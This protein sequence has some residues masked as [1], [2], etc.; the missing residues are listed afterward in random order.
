MSLD[1][2]IFEARAANAGIDARLLERLDLNEL[3]TLRRELFEMFHVDF[4]SEGLAAFKGR[5]RTYA[6]ATGFDPGE[7]MD[8]ICKVALLYPALRRSIIGQDHVLPKVCRA[9]ANGLLSKPDMAR[10]RPK[11]S[12]MFLGPTGVGKTELALEFTRVVFDGDESRLV[13]LDMSEFYHEDSY[14]LFAGR[15]GEPGRIGEALNKIESGGTLLLDEIEKANREIMKYLLQML[16]AGRITCGDGKTYSTANLYIV[17]TSN[18]GADKIMRANSS[19]DETVERYVKMQLYKIMRPETVGRLNMLCVF[20]RLEMDSLRK[21]CRQFVDLELARIRHD[22]GY[23]A[24]V[25]EAAFELILRLGTDLVL[26]ARPTRDTVSR[27]LGD[28][29]TSAQIKA[30]PKGQYVCDKGASGEFLVLLSFQP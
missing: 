14:E 20:R 8:R 11:S 27:L 5:I 13:R 9:V 15:P 1:G 28:A 6:E 25:S 4:L 16:D 21:I 18:I 19:L 7:Y 2:G 24:E 12:M 30:F 23:D 29:V 26:G 22:Y 3:E 17:L 10:P